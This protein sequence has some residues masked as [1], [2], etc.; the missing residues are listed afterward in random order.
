MQNDHIEKAAK[1]F[2]IE[3]AELNRVKDR[4]DESFAKAVEAIRERVSA[5]H[6]VLT[7]GVGKCSY[8]A[9]KIAA[10]L[11]STG[12]PALP[13]DSMNA[14][15]GDLGVVA[16]GDVVIALS[17][18]GETEEMLTFLTA[19]RRFSVTII[20]LTGNPKSELARHS[21]FII[22]TRVEREACPLELAPTSSTTSMLVLG[23]ALAMVLLEASG[24]C[25]EDF[26]RFHPGGSIGRRLLMT[27][28]EMMR[29]LDE[30]AVVAT[31]TT[32]GDALDVMT[33]KR[34]GA[35]VVT[36]GEGRVAG[37][38]THGDFVRAFKQH[39]GEIS[40]REV[41]AFMS[42]NPITTHVDK[43]AVEVVGVLKAHRIDEIIVA[44]DNNQPAGMIDVQDLARLKIV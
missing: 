7:V 8:I 39:G 6:K 24:F 20:C 31:G 41:D 15:H 40:P 4:L 23:D 10:T 21:D 13:L 22:N 42:R 3:I 9:A 1:V 28:R 16:D 33:S 19:L 32:V 26:A 25:R 17:Y 35:A 37:I 38:F 5:G 34:A 29:P 43:L 11:T 30:I 2:E 44:D 12:T 14:L 27:A 18:S 36:D